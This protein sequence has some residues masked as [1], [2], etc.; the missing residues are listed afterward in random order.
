MLHDEYG[1]PD[2]SLKLLSQKIGISATHLGR[3]FKELAANNFHSYLLELRMNNA[4]RLLTTSM[5]DIKTVANFSWI[6]GPKPFQRPLPSC[7]W[8]H[9]S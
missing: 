3:R 9:S 8:L 1:N 4:A 2:L 7:T 6:Y 5:Q